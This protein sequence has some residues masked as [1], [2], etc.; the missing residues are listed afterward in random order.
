MGC[1]RRILRCHGVGCWAHSSQVDTVYAETHIN[2]LPEGE[3]RYRYKTSNFQIERF[4]AETHQ[5]AWKPTNFY[6]RRTVA[7]AQAVGQNPLPRQ[8]AHLSGAFVPRPN[9][10]ERRAC[11]LLFQASDGADLIWGDRL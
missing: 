4:F 11:L 7:A 5:I 10:R 9:D 1:L 2:S 3:I 8:Y 6:A